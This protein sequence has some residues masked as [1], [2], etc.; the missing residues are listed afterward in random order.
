MLIAAVLA[1]SLDLQIDLTKLIR[2]ADNAQ[3]RGL[4][5]GIKTVGYRF[6]GKPGQSFRYAGDTYTVPEEGAIELI[7]SR[8]HDTYKYADK[9][10]PL[11]VW[12][13]DP[14][15]FRIVPLPKS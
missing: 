13:M 5:C 6:V 12:P 15:G 7:A 11:E 2:R 14:F 9:A 3:V 10:L 1:A 8:R 4:T